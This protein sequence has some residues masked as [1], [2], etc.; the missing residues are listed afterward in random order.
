MLSILNTR[1]EAKALAASIHEWR[2]ANIPGYTATSWANED[3]PDEEYDAIHKAEKEEKWAVA[4][5]HDNK[6]ATVESAAQVG[7]LPAGWRTEETLR[8]A[9]RAEQIVD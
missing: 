1:K 8:E 2:K 5:A 7:S 3:L 4:L 9:E 6:G